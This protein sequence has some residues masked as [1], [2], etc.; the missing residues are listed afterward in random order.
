MFIVHILILVGIN[1][2]VHCS[3]LLNQLQALREWSW[4]ENSSDTTYRS[5]Y[6]IVVAALP[7]G[8]TT[9][10]SHCFARALLEK[11]VLFN[12]W[13]E[14]VWTMR[15]KVELCAT[16]DKRERATRKVLPTILPVKS[17]ITKSGFLSLKF[18]YYMETRLGKMR[19]TS[20]K[21]KHFCLCEAFEK[22]NLSGIHVYSDDD[23][24]VMMMLMLRGYHKLHII[25]MMI[26][27]FLSYGFA[28]QTN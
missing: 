26:I 7:A 28:A 24:R 19:K 1:S 11:S 25:M 20:D 6:I 27:I 3:V 16:F 4:L 12:C 10:F 5:S 13:I 9:C 8:Q 21:A 17:T 18:N 15:W 23:G 2:V 22:L 14:F